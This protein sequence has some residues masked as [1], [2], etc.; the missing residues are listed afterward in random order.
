VGTYKP[1]P[2]VNLELLDVRMTAILLQSLLGRKTQRGPPRRTHTH[3]RGGIFVGGKG[4]L[5]SEDVTSNIMAFMQTSKK[6]DQLF[7]GLYV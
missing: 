2:E 1:I 5:T 3:G 6:S 4:I 7:P